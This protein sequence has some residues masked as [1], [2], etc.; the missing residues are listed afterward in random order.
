MPYLL[1]RLCLLFVLLVSTPFVMAADEPV[2]TGYF[3]NVAVGGHDMIA[4]RELGADDKAIKGEKIY[5]VEWKG[6]DW[7]FVTEEDSQR[8]AANPEKFAPAYNGHCANALSLGEGLINTNGKTW[9]IFDE[10][11]YLFYAP[12]GA[13]R[14]KAADDYREYKAQADKAWREILAA[15]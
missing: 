1:N 10:Q 9:A 5:T 11:L 13:R 2:S 14:W 4:Y 12:R 7:H 8:F 6:A 3:N 15:R